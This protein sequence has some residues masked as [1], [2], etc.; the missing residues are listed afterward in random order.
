MKQASLLF[1][2]THAKHANGINVRQNK[3]I[4]GQGIVWFGCMKMAMAA[5]NVFAAYH[6]YSQAA[7]QGK[8]A[9]YKLARWYEKKQPKKAIKLYQQA[10]KQGDKNTKKRLK[11]LTHPT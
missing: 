4:N 1:K 3:A 9:L 5:K 11:H 8:V 10:A 7:Q 2:L 6:C